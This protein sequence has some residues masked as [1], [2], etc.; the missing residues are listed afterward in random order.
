[1]CVV[2]VAH[3]IDPRFPLVLLLNRDEFYARPTAPLHRWEGGVLAGR[4]LRG[5]GTWMGVDALGRWGVI[6]NFR[7]PDQLKSGKRSRGELIPQFLHQRR[8]A[9]AFLDAL[10]AR[11]PK[12]AAFNLLLGDA[13]G[14][15]Y[16]GSRTGLQKQPSVGLYGLSNAQFDTPWPKVVRGKARLRAALDAASGADALL[17]LMADTH[18][19]PEHLLPDTGVGIEME[20]GLSS[21]FV[22]MPELAYGTRTTT[23]LRIDGQGQVEVVER[24]YD[25]E[26]NIVGQQAFC[27][28]AGVR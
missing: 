18:R 27:F 17:D 20:A 22:Q 9:P 13:Q 28:E 6:T 10:R 25:E 2:Y 11:M 23:L 26:G 24:G 4:D 5:G 7:A 8:T 21:V 12:Y 16:L 3:G 19:P 1:M 14:L 15:A